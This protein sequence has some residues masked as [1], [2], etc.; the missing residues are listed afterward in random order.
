MNS[1]VVT[2]KAGGT[3]RLCQKD[4]KIPTENGIY[5]SGQFADDEQGREPV[6]LFYGLTSSEK[7]QDSALGYSLINAQT[8]QLR[9]IVILKSALWID[10]AISIA[11]K[12]YPEMES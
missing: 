11:S 12:I 2:V 10:G 6:A 7:D 5:A 3:R 8:G 9:I 1:L 4:V